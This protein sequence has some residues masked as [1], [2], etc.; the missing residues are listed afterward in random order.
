VLFIHHDLLELLNFAYDFKLNN[1]IPNDQIVL[2]EDDTEA[3]DDF[4]ATTLVFILN[5]IP[6]AIRTISSII[7]RNE[8]R[9]IS[10]KYVVYFVPKVDHFCLDELARANLQEKVEIFGFNFG[11][12]SVNPGLISLELSFYTHPVEVTNLSVEALMKLSKLTGRFSRIIGKGEKS[13]VPVIQ[14][15]QSSSP[16]RSRCRRTIRLIPAIMAACSLRSIGRSIPSRP[17]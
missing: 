11:L 6:T 7:L 13:K 5:P 17:S 15:R 12:I 4:K 14:Y 1:L 8:T 16:T 3:I 2:F 10:K 9:A